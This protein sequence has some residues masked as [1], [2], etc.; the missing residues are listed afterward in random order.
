[1][2]KTSGVYYVYV[3]KVD[4]VVKYIG[5]GKKDRY[6]HCTSGVSSCPE[7]NRD[8]FAGKV[9]DVEIVKKGLSEEDAKTLEADMIRNDIDNLYNRVIKHNPIIKPNLRTIRDIKL[10]GSNWSIEEREKKAYRQKIEDVFP[11]TE[12]EANLLETLIQAGLALY[13]IELPTGTRVITIDKTDDIASYE[14]SAQMFSHYAHP[15][16]LYDFRCGVEDELDGLH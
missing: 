9:M 3:C 1:M 6:K 4:G 2:P 13:V 7:L 15:E 12:T 5:M 8:F 11:N 10:I 14:F 16:G